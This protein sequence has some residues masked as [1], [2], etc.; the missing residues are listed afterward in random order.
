MGLIWKYAKQEDIPEDVK[1]FYIERRGEWV[2]DVQTD[3]AENV[4]K[5]NDKLRADVDR[6]QAEKGISVKKLKEIEDRFGNL[7][8]VQEKLSN[9]DSLQTEI[10]TLRTGKGSSA[11]ELSKLRTDY[12]KLKKDFEKKNAEFDSVNTEYLKFKKELDWKDA[13]SAITSIVESIPGVNQKALRRSLISQYQLGQL[14]RDEAG[15]I[16][17]PTQKL[18][19]ETHAKGFAEDMGLLAPSQAGNS[20]PGNSTPN[21]EQIK[22]QQA[23]EAAKAK[24]DSLGMLNAMPQT[25]N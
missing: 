15:K 20:H 17:E 19:L 10:E 18:D 22:N 7:D 1:N 5:V 12:G 4:F 9:L 25:T 13:E 2:V 16:I 21:S 3:D 14:I 24:G 23:Y 6:L 8:E 11:E